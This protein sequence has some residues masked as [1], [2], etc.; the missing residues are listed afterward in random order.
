MG[1]EIERKF[2]VKGSFIL[3]SVREVRIIQAYLSADPLRT[4]RVRISDD[5]AFLTIKSQDSDQIHDRKEWEVKIDLTDAL[6]ILEICLPGRIEKTRYI[7]PVGIHK[8]E[9]DVFHGKNEGL[10]VAEVELGSSDEFFEKPEWLGEEVTGKP[11][12]YNSS[13][14]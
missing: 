10:V 12:F 13:L 3:D 8:F 5:E 6:E 7:V 4:I 1:R 9:V 11:E 14:I 2:L